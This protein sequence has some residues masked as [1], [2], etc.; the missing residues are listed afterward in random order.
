M[1]FNYKM[2]KSK[3]RIIVAILFLTLCATGCQTSEQ[4]QAEDA[5]R[6]AEGLQHVYEMEKG[7]YEDM[8]SDFDEYNR[9]RDRLE[10]AK[11]N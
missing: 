9:A 1:R 11:D 10:R 2:K 8:K 3:K 6:A 5:R 4:K 7:R